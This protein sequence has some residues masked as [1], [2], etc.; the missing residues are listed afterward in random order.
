MTLFGSRRGAS[1]AATMMML[2]AFLG[3]GGFMYWLNGA[4]QPAEVEV[5]EEPVDDGTPRVTYDDFA[6]DPATHLGQVIRVTGVPV[7]SGFG[8]NGFWTQASG[9]QPFLVHVSGTPTI[10]AGG[11]AE[12]VGSVMSMSDSVL[13]AW[14]E[15]GHIAGAG[16]R[17]AAEFS[18]AFFE[19]E[20]VEFVAGG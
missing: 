3:I 9:G 19:A 5:V 15:A 16:D 20:S 1:G 2:V 11:T 6:T 4:A 17:A 14:E 7:T 13:T 18:E 12:M 8:S 10:P